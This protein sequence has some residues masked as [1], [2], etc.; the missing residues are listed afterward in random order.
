MKKDEIQQ[1]LEEIKK[2]HEQ[3]THG[4]SIDQ[5]A[6]HIAEQNQKKS[7]PTAQPLSFHFTPAGA[8]PNPVD[9]E[10]LNTESQA[11]SSS[12]STKSANPSMN[13]P[14][15]KLSPRERMEQRR[16]QRGQPPVNASSANPTPAVSANAPPAPGSHIRRRMGQV[17][18]GNG[19][20]MD[21]PN[22]SDTPENM[23]PAAE[24]D[25]KDL[26]A[27]DKHAG[28]DAKKKKKKSS[29][30]N[31]DDADMDGDGELS[32]DEED[33]ELLDEDEK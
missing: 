23:A 10:K 9:A 20:E 15:Q 3:T 13:I 14:A 19:N 22:A 29:A 11:K 31:D 26:F 30:E 2:L 25:F 16:M 17:Q 21:A 1:A 28:A 12:N 4:D 27:D 7:N 32:E 5:M 33:L 6:E 24:E 18:A 8:A